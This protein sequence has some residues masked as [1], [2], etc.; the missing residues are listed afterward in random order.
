M[1]R[2]ISPVALSRSRLSASCSFRSRDETPETFAAILPFADFVGRRRGLFLRFMGGARDR[3]G[4]ATGASGE[5]R[6]DGG[7]AA[8][9]IAPWRVPSDAR[10]GRLR[11]PGEHGGGGAGDGRALEEARVARAEHADRVGEREVA[12]V[13]G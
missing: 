12:E 13:F 1:A 7:S 5:A 4:E 8:A 11:R 9:S 10:R 6:S 3:L 2:R